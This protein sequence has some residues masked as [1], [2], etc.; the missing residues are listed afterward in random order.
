[1]GSIFA[2][3]AIIVIITL[4]FVQELSSQII[5]FAIGGIIAFLG[6][7]L[8]LIG[9]IMLSKDYKEYKHNRN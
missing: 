4:F 9:E 2:T 3:T 1:M 5:G 8:D 6:I 7:I